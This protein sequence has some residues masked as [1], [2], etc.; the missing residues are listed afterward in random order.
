MLPYGGLL[1]RLLLYQCHCGYTLM[2]MAM[3][4]SFIEA[5]LQ[6]I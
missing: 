6:S 3:H 1:P 5:L 2:S 4:S